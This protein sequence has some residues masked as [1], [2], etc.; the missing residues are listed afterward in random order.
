MID[1]RMGLFAFLVAL[2]FLVCLGFGAHAIWVTGYWKLLWWVLPVCWLFAWMV[3]HWLKRSERNNDR[4]AVNDSSSSY[5]EHESPEHRNSER[6]HP[7]HWDQRDEAAS[8]IIEKH[9]QGFS[10][11]DPANL[12]D[13]HHYLSVAQ[14]L[15]TELAEFYHGN[16][17]PQSAT[18]PT[19]APSSAAPSS[20]ASAIDSLTVVEVAAAA[21]LAI[22]DLEAW[23]LQSVPGSRLL[24][25]RQ[26]QNVTQAPK[27]YSYVS[28]IYWGTSTLI[29]P[30]NL[31]RYFTSK[32]TMGTVAGQLQSEV[33]ATIYVNFLRRVGF[34]LIEMNSGRL[35]GG[36]EAYAD[37]FGVD[38]DSRP[39]SHAK[40]SHSQ[41]NRIEQPL[42]MTLVGQVSSGKSSLIN[43][44]MGDAVAKVD[45]LPETQ[46]V[47]RYEH[48]LDCLDGTQCALTFL[49]TP[50]YD[51]SGITPQQQ[52]EIETAA[53]H[54]DILLL[55]IDGHSPAREAD[56]Q[57]IR[58][59]HQHFQDHPKLRQPP[60]VCVLTHI[61]MIPPASV[62]SPP[63][64][65]D[66]PI[67][68]KEENIRGAMDYAAEVFRESGSEPFAGIVSVCTSD[69]NGQPWGV[70]ENLLPELVRHLDDG[71]SAS[72]IRVFE[73]R[74]DSDRMSNVMS[75]I[76][77]LAGEALR[78]WINQRHTL[79]VKS[80]ADDK[81]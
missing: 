10:S 46:S 19:A 47:A 33:I 74:V 69:R 80:S 30:T 59:V 53:N 22:D 24:T 54:S 15:A 79:G 52:Q 29:N 36:A 28:K 7:A 16:A 50:G 3:A 23:V 35:R 70:V 60:I 41:S 62:W 61:D 12:S 11:L 75:Q 13:P 27:W 65:L 2:P 31:I 63:Y 6:W 25:I 38:F 72:L 1:R 37:T 14:S 34:Y 49:D 77:R 71:R 21:R 56:L 9:Q 4:F 78:G 18:N 42:V 64:N 57:M 26:W 48:A 51:D 55:V 44:I 32:A 20:A 17:A 58:S 43:A 5:P 81:V 67:E 76:K 8:K 66:S 39:K 73:S 40:D 68:A 45:V